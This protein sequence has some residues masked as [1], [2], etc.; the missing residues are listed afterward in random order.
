MDC[1]N[2]VCVRVRVRA[3]VR[4]CV[5]VCCV[6]VCV[7]ISSPNDWQRWK[8]DIVKLN[9]QSVCK[10]HMHLTLYEIGLQ[11]DKCVPH[12]WPN[13]GD[14][15]VQGL[16]G[17][18]IPLDVGLLNNVLLIIL[19][20][21]NIPS[22]SQE[23]SSSVPIWWHKTIRLRF[24]TDPVGTWELVCY[25]GCDSLWHRGRF[26]FSYLISVTVRDPLSK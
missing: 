11:P 8:I 22:L 14:V 13:D 10:D 19:S 5:C 3:C 17:K 4:A 7:H 21:T 1:F 26:I 25:M 23:T 20:R 6:C 16:S 12:T 15:E 2:D 18:E 9:T 24:H